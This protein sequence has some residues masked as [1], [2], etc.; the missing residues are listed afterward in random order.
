MVRF[1]RV[2]F[3][4]GRVVCCA[5]LAVMVLLSA[6]SSLKVQETWYNPAKVGSH[7]QKLMVLFITPDEN[8]RKMVENIVVDELGRNGVRGVACHTY[9]KDLDKAH[10]DDVVAA[11]RETGADGVIT[12]QAVSV[13]D[14]TVTQQGVPSG[15]VYGTAG[16]GYYS[17]PGSGSFL[18]ANLQTNLY[19]SQTAQVVWTATIKTF[20]A[21]NEARVSRD[22]ARF[23]VE[24]LRRDGFL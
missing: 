15:A 13:G 17:L 11:V 10:R 7:Y 9:V 24:R 18:K 22:L 20:D 3:F 4:A 21:E 1:S 5:L 23:F 19:D 2:Q 12:M 16:N 14:Q 8:R 6:C